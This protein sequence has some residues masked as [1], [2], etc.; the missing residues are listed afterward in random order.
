MFGC[1]SNLVLT[2]QFALDN[3]R[4][5]SIS[6]EENPVRRDKVQSVGL[7]DGDFP[8]S[9]H[10]RDLGFR[11]WLTILLDTHAQHGRRGPPL[12][13]VHE[14]ENGEKMWK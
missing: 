2:R 13:P 10:C 1:D 8:G 12:C 9:Q 4:E 5:L 14:P 3:L 6:Y 7:A 11:F